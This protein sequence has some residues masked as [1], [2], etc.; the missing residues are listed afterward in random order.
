MVTTE[1]RRE[2]SP[3]MET[4]EV[5]LGKL[6]KAKKRVE[7]KDLLYRIRKRVSTRRPSVVRKEVVVLLVT[8]VGYLSAEERFTL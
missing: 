4:E 5:Y 6:Q 2:E 8:K 3:E 7:K 1:S